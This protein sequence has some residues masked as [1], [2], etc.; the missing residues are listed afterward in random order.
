MQRIENASGA[1]AVWGSTIAVCGQLLGWVSARAYVNRHRC[2]WGIAY[3]I[4]NVLFFWQDNHCRESHSA[5]VE[6]AKEVLNA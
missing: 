6:F 4:I 3:R 2:G 5:D 1:T